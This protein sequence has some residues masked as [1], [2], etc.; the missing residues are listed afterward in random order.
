VPTGE[1]KI[2]KSFVNWHLSSA[3][4]SEEKNFPRFFPKCLARVQWVVRVDIFSMY[5][6]R[7]S[8]TDW[9]PN[10]NLVSGGKWEQEFFARPSSFDRSRGY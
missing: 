7:K 3:G 4:V 9:G 8:F 10:G 6:E 1:R 5:V 2:S